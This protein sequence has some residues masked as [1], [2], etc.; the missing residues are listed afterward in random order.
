MF[1]SIRTL[2]GYTK[3]EQYNTCSVNTD[4]NTNE[5]IKFV[6]IR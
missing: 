3:I 4:S 1:F 5:T 2:Q 6:K